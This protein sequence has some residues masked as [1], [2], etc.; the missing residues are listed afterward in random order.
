MG[1]LDCQQWGNSSEHSHSFGNPDRPSARYSRNLDRRRRRSDTGVTGEPA[2][3]VSDFDLIEKRLDCAW[4]GSCK[5]PPVSRSSHQARSSPDIPW[6]PGIKRSMLREAGAGE[7]P[8]PGG[9][10]IDDTLAGETS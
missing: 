6:I 10:M 3:P 5:A 9:H 7:T 2:A 8:H 4:V 1:R